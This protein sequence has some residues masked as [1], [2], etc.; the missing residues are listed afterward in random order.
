MW[1]IHLILVLIL[2]VGAVFFVIF[3]GSRTIDIIS[4]GFADY[5]NISLNVVILE[6]FLIGALWALIVFFFIQ[7][8]SRIKMMKLKKKNRY[9]QDELDSLRTLPLEDISLGEEGEDD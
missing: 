7:I 8:S 1:I 9:L 2:I 5:T 3:N 4:L 6:S